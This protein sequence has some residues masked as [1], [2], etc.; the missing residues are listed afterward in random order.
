MKN[1]LSRFMISTALA[2][3]LLITPLAVSFAAG[4]TGE[5]DSKEEV[6]YSTLS[7]DGGVEG[8]YV[9]NIL[10]VTR[11]GVVTDF[12]DFESIKNLTNTNDLEYSGGKIS[13]YAEE[14]RFYY[15]GN[16]SNGQLPW[17]VDIG[18]SLDGAEIEA[19][20]L[21]GKSGALEMSIRTRANSAV[22]PA[23]YDN[24]MLQ[25]SVTLDSEL[26][27]NIAAPGAAFANSGTDK[28]LTFTVLP[29]KDGD[30]KITADVTNFEMQGVSIA[31]IPFSMDIDVGDA[32]SMSGD[33]QS[34]SD[35]VSQLS[36]G[37]AELSSG[38][39]RLNDASDALASGSGTYKSGL[40]SLAANSQRMK[41]GSAQILLALQYIDDSLRANG[42][43]SGSD[44]SGL[45]QLPES[46]AGLGSS[47]TS[48]S[49]MLSQLSS[50][51][52]QALSALSSA[53][54]D[55]PGS[56]LTESDI[57]A[58]MTANPNSAALQTLIA[59][60]QAA[61][62][63][64]A[65]YEQVR[66]AF[67]SV[68]SALPELAASISQ[69]GSGLTAMSGQLSAALNGS[70]MLTAL[71]E[72]TAGISELTKNYAVFN[73]GLISYIDGV[74]SLYDGYAQLDSGISAVSD[75]LSAI[76]GAGAQ[77]SDAMNTLNS[78]T[79]NLPDKLQTAI[80]D[81][82]AEYDVSDFIPRSFISSKNSN[83]GSV[84]F[85]ITSAA[86]EIIQPAATEQPQQESGGFFSRLISLFTSKK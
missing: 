61:Q 67:E 39:A 28:L 18:Y 37:A 13:V 20:E 4:D 74:D 49:G 15:Q 77:L 25:I 84:Q 3:A 33:L 22:D 51:Y 31:G 9:V 38:I 42:D 6:V 59:S 16:L 73:A 23:F 26:C 41:D 40:N 65:T 10:N 62:T 81:M 36:S 83:V 8:I 60:Y 78:E 71:S 14:G 86:I 5:V 44:L 80:D 75:G 24:Y 19:S 35:A 21:A 32:T 46:L 56:T 12:G 70:G 53:I 29:G 64:K 2:L 85:V 47:L 43:G 54:S 52:T 72:L 68:D 7:A 58:L 76:A 57:A 34:L 17:A 11:A 48:I 1:K 27:R 63:V 79:Q 66:T 30:M 45:L 55:I 82:I 69:M 50:G